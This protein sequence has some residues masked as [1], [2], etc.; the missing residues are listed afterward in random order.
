MPL[1]HLSEISEHEISAKLAATLLTKAASSESLDD[2]QTELCREI[3]STTKAG[4]IALM[5][6][7][8]GVWRMRANAGKQTQP[9]TE[10]LAE[11]LDA[12]SPQQSGEWFG[13]PVDANAGYALVALGWQVEQP[14]RCIEALAA[15]VE[16]SLTIAQRRIANLRRVNRLE[17][18]LDIAAHWQQTLD[19]EELLQNMAEASTRLL[20]AERAS[21]FLWDKPNKTLIGRPALGVEGNELRIPD[22]AGIVGQVVQTGEN[23]RVDIDIAAEQQEID[24]TVD[25]KLQFQTRSIV[26]VPLRDAE[27][28]MLGAFEVLN[29]HSGYFND[30]DEAAL[31][32]LAAHAGIA[33]QNTQHYESLMQNASVV[34]DQ[35]A[36]GVRL[37]GGCAQIVA[38]RSTVN[39]I[40][41]AEDLAVLILGENGTGKEVI[42]QMI[43]Y[44]SKRRNQAFVAVNCAAISETLL[45]SELFGHEKGAFTDAHDTRIGKFELAS[46]GTLFLDEIGDMSLGGQAKLLRVLEEKMVVRVGGSTPIYT[47]ARVIAA[48]NQNL[49][50]MVREKKFREDLYYRLNVATL[51]LPPLRERGDDILLLA[52]FFMKDFSQ[53]AR[54]KAPKFTAAAKTRLLSHLWPGNV[55]ELRNLMERLAYL[56]QDDKIQPEDLAFILAPGDDQKN[57]MDLNLSLNDATQQFQIDYIQQHIDRVRGKMTQAA[58]NLGLHRSNLYRKMK[59]LGMDDGE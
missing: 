34:A 17:A 50:N 3:K 5:Q 44:H 21:I 56:S 33:L 13:A 40:A 12:N 59:Q 32:E 52:E 41:A 15:L 11:I 2:F 23:R 22:D 8:K 39:R 24:R 58:K 4:C 30:D 46:G 25:E 20:N 18:T 57:V 35:A 31:V 51:E 10:F 27:G 29:K 38:L 28:E 19:M 45:E 47:D 37:I 9:P 49:A 16:T 43:H 42:S 48:T 36:E 7:A 54:R 55:R 26:C 14:V 6:G 1:E 53:K